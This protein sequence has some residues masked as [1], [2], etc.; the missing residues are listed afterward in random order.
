MT[1]DE[2]ALE[3]KFQATSTFLLHP[4][5]KVMP[6]KFLS[7]LF[8]TSTLH[9]RPRPRHALSPL[10]MRPNW[11]RT[12]PSTL[13][14]QPA[15]I[16]SL[17]DYLEATDTRGFI[18]LHRGRIV[19]EEYFGDF[20]ESDTWYWASAGKSLRATLVGEARGR[21][22]LDIEAP[23]SDYLGRGWATSLTA[24]QEDSIQR[25]APCSV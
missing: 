10:W 2:F 7:L 9:L 21:G 24:E 3:D 20:T 15:A 19:L 18:L 6:T 25:P 5:N 1:C 16:D 8:A 14:Y 17:Y 12:D 23:V 4:M 13:G 11:E 22:L